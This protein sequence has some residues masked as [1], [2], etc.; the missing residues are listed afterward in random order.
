M[1]TIAD[2]RP[3]VV[4]HLAAVTHIY[5]AT[6]DDYAPNVA[7]VENLLYA[8]Q[9]APS[10]RRTVCTSSQ[11]V[12]HAGYV[13]S[14]DEDYRPTTL[15]GESKVRTEQLWRAASGVGREWCIVRPTT[16]WGPGMNRHYLT[17]FGMLRRGR[18]VHVGR[19]PIRKT[20]GFVGNTV[21]QL[22][23]LA[24]A[25]PEAIHGRT[26]YLGDYEPLDL[27]EWAETFREVLGAPRIRTI[28]LPVAWTVARTGDMINRLGYDRFPFNSFRLRNVI[29][30]SILDLSS[31]EDVCGPLPFTMQDGVG[32]TVEWL[33]GIWSGAESHVPIP[34]TS[35]SATSAA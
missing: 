17:F 19:Q 9:R 7:G 32:Y 33:R 11:L 13:S 20:Y 22:R 18:Y 15:Y 23:R 5:G 34:A 25:L 8:I 21:H 12:C 3:D 24:E 10:V 29:T 2:T 6:L 31:T 16:I 27:F 26:F 28:P 14:R 1:R 30:S 4:V 35:P